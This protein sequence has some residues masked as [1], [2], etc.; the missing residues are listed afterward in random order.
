METYKITEKIYKPIDIEITKDK[1]GTMKHA[2]QLGTVGLSAGMSDPRGTLAS[3]KMSRAARLLDYL[4]L[5]PGTVAAYE[6]T[7]ANQLYVEIGEQKCVVD[8]GAAAGKCFLRFVEGTRNADLQELPV[9][10]VALSSFVPNPS[11][12]S[13]FSSLC[14]ASAAGTLGAS[15]ADDVIKFC[16]EFYYAFAKDLEVEIDDS[17]TESEIEAAFRSGGFAKPMD[18][19]VT[20]KLSL[21]PVSY[22]KVKAK[23]KAK[24]KGSTLQDF[25]QDCKDG[26]YR[27]AHDWPEVMKKYMVSVSF[28]DT[29]EPT[30][31]FREIVMKVKFRCDRIQERIDQGLTGADAI[32]NDVVNLMI[33][34]KPGTGKTV[35]TRAVAA[36]CGFPCCSTI[37]SK[38]T[39]E[40][41]IEGKT[42]I[43]DGKPQFVY[44]DALTFHENGGI[45][46]NEEINLAAA[47]VTMGCL[48]QKLEYPYI[49]KKNGYENIVRNPFNIVIATMN[50][51][52]NG[53]N[54]LNQALAN[55]FG[56]VFVMD[57]PDRDTFI[58]ILKK[59][60]GKSEEVC[61]WM[62]EAYEKCISYLKDPAVNAEEIC[63]TLSIRTCTNAIKLMEEGTDARRALANTIC[64][65]VATS[66]LEVANNMEREVINALPNPDFDL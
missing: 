40:G 3:G 55:R 23:K 39:D 46:V 17:L 25:L 65:T 14:T 59:K 45:D 62:Y 11:L 30:R 16:D 9:V 50:V 1:D 26:K 27:V 2:G 38:N 56:A 42:V 33:V 64:G 47:S 34:G 5:Y 19:L 15:K 32:G 63:D 52:T 51:G 18:I 6:G 61:T 48:G 41:E 57:D 4:F 35:L 58:G 31:E 24:K 36:A 12:K 60:S 66:D 53:S 44:T 22:N 43:V 37:F 8:N 13:Y 7:A 28:L 54:P 49:V 29:Y 10:L 20:N 21:K